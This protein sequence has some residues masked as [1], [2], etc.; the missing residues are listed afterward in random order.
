M[1]KFDIKKSQ[2]LPSDE[3]INKH[4]N[5][6]K[7]MK[8]AALYEYKQA[9]K[10]IYKNVK[11]LS[12]VAVIIAVGLIILF[13]TTEHEDVTTKKTEQIHTENTAQIIPQH[14][15]TKPVIPKH[16][17]ANEEAERIPQNQSTSTESTNTTTHST[18]EENN[19]IE[20]NEATIANFPGGDEAL[21]AFLLK[22]IKYPYNAIESP[23]SG[24][25]EVELVIEKK[26]E[27][28]SFII[29]HNPNSAISNEIKRVIKLMPKWQ[30]AT[31]N[32]Q[33][34]VSKVTVYFPF[35]YTA[36]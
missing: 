2:E 12:A 14:D 19:L 33:P 25:I 28:S 1:S 34:I 26:G 16:T 10:P 35:T 17:S 27:V 29:Y 31:K 22:N 8:K 3:E 7:V 15:T 30:A 36:E 13:E 18:T 32:N 24:K 9:T 5:F 4:K 11:V 23:Y 20:L 21:Q 6:D